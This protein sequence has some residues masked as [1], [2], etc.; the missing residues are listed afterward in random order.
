MLIAGL[1]CLGL[2]AVAAYFFFS[3]RKTLQAAVG[4]ETLKCGEVNELSTAA[5]AAVGAGSFSHACEVVGPAKA[6][7]TGVLKASESGQ[8]CVW[9]RSK[10]T[11][12]YWDWERDSEGDMDR[13]R[14]TREIHSAESE[15]PFFVDDGTGRIEIVPVGAD[16]DGADKVVDRMD[17]DAGSSGWSGFASSVFGGDRTIGI[18]HEE[19]I[20][21]PGARLYVL[22][23][24]SDKSGQLRIG[25]ADKGPFVIS[26]RSEEEFTSATR[27]TM[28]LAL[29]A[30]VVLGIAAPVLIVLGLI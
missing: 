18:E 23:E 8:E 19:W 3:E 13:T 4:T 12:H 5:A 28:R 24:A 6:P 1:V 22:G 14:K 27:T 16:I 2:A 7:E 15:T 26:T 11:E 20:I 30:A 29:A 10:L 21:R 17:K 25:Q 9:H